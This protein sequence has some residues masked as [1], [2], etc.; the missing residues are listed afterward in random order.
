LA[1]DVD[2]TPVEDFGV[3]GIQGGRARG[4]ILHKLIEEVLTGETAEAEHDLLVRAE[5][6][7]RAIARTV[8]DNPAQGLAPTELAACVARALALPEI[9]ALRPRL[10]PEVPVYA[11]VSTVE[12]EEEEEE[13][14]TAGFADAIAVG[15]DGAP[16][17]VVDWKTDVAPTPETLEHY[18]AQVRA[19]LDMTET[20]RGLIVFA[21]SG[22][23]I[24]VARK[25]QA[26]ASCFVT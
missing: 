1:S 4:I 13:E 5:V 3:L 16:Q 26:V 23:V 21:T 18:R 14:A 25:N 6:L 7:T 12:E 9:V 2:G 17:V 19:Y 11:S 8:A 10:L 15:D 22:V 24:S 20:L